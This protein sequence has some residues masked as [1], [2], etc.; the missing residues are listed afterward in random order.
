MTSKDGAR[1]ADPDLRTARE[2]LDAMQAGESL[3]F[4]RRD[5][6]TLRIGFDGT[7]YSALCADGADK[8]LIEKTALGERLVIGAIERYLAGDAAGCVKR[9]SRPNLGI[10]QR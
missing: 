4:N 10:V 7:A 9:L 6:G 3:A 8:V 5:R 2:W 1:C